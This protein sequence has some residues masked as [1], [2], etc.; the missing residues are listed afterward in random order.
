MQFRIFRTRAFVSDPTN[1]WD[2]IWN[3]GKKTK[4]RNKHLLGFASAL[5]DPNLCLFPVL[6]EGE[7]AS[8]PA[9]LDELVGFCDEL[10]GEYPAGELSVGCNGVGLWVPRDLGDLWCGEGEVSRRLDLGV[11]EGCTLEPV[12]QEQLGVVLAD[13]CEKEIDERVSR[14]ERR[15]NEDVLVPL[16]DIVC[17]QV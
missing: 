4:G 17:G 13:S 14:W 10:G 9:T 16:E 8:L 15:T 6:V 5:R 2:M 12:G 11:D 7:Q 3:R 1:V